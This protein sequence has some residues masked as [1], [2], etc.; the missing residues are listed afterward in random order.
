VAARTC[1]AAERACVFLQD[2][3]LA[4]LLSR[5]VWHTPVHDLSAV[6]TDGQYIRAQSG[7]PRARTAHA[8]STAHPVGLPPVG[9]RNDGTLSVSASGA[10]L[11]FVQCS[12]ASL[13][14][15]RRR[16]VLLC[17]FTWHPRHAHNC[18]TL[19]THKHITAVQTEVFRQ[20]ADAGSPPP[21][22]L[23]AGVERSTMVRLFWKAFDSAPQRSRYL[24]HPAQQRK[25]L[26]DSELLK[27]P[28]LPPS[29]RAREAWLSPVG[30]EQREE[31][32][33]GA[34]VVKGVPGVVQ[35]PAAPLRPREANELLAQTV[36]MASRRLGVQR[37]IR[38]H[39]EMLTKRDHIQQQ[40]HSARLRAVSLARGCGLGWGCAYARESLLCRRKRGKRA[41]L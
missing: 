5:A 36:R 19:M 14:E 27:L 3:R 15:A 8:A 16:A 30:S 34:L 39:E 28:G 40:A 37:R 24:F 25:I 10:P 12:F 29:A 41:A 7:S 11:H 13:E 38:E 4:R 33:E 35:G 6:A 21:R 31:S 17:L 26:P 22:T 23:S 2:F 1:Y 18:V 9:A 32:P 20:C